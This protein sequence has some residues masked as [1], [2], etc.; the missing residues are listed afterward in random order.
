MEYYNTFEEDDGI[1]ILG[2]NR[3]LKLKTLLNRGESHE[4]SDYYRDKYMIHLYNITSAMYGYPLTHDISV[5]SI[6]NG[7]NNINMI[8]KKLYEFMQISL[9]IV[10]GISR[11]MVDIRG[12]LEEVS[13][14]IRKESYD[15]LSNHLKKYHQG[16]ITTVFSIIADMDALLFN[17]NTKAEDINNYLSE[18]SKFGVV[19]NFNSTFIKFREE[20]EEMVYDYIY[21]I[22]TL[23]SDIF[24]ES[25]VKFIESNKN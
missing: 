3:K 25:F 14:K 16:N 18:S 20:I 12:K 9:D 7:A 10:T 23:Y 17:S 21:S 19:Y 24:H 1:M 5:E 13:E 22:P 4:I 6:C 8:F 2:E 11:T 15:F